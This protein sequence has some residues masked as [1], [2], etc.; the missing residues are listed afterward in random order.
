MPTE[1]LSKETYV[2][3]ILGLTIHQQVPKLL[4]KNFMVWWLRHWTAKLYEQ[5]QKFSLRK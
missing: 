2:N 5:Q 3:Y 1:F 4:K